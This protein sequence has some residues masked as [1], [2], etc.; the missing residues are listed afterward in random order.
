MTRKT[1]RRLMLYSTWI[2]K[3]QIPLFNTSSPQNSLACNSKTTL[4]DSSPNSLSLE[5]Q[6][7]FCFMKPHWSP[8]PYS[9]SSHQLVCSSPSSNVHSLKMP[10]PSKPISKDKHSSSPLRSSSENLRHQYQH[11]HMV[12]L[13]SW[14]PHPSNYQHNFSWQLYTDC[15]PRPHWGCKCPFLRQ[16]RVSTLKISFNNRT[17][18]GTKHPINR[19]KSKLWGQ[20][21]ESLLKMTCV[22]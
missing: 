13:S 9:R 22:S 10:L 12:S 8:L 20:Q 7:C 3:A 16:G 4:W 19:Q 6:V 2:L 5:Q 11:S 17:E 1:V 21:P 15:S 18:D 14:A